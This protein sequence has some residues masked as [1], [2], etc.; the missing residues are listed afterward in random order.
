MSSVEHKNQ[1]GC[2]NSFQVFKV[3]DTI[4]DSVSHSSD[5]TVYISSENR[6]YLK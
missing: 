4:S 2:L 5:A 3:F 1:G 6:M